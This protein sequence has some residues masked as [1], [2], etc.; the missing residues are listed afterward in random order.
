MARRKLASDGNGH[1]VGRKL[2][3]QPHVPVSE[4][5]E[6]GTGDCCIWKAAHRRP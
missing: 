4:W 5:G 6:G 2:D 1:N 3:D